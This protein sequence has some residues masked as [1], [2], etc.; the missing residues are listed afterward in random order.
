M[1]SSAAMGV[2]C[3]NGEGS[4][5]TLMSLNHSFPLESHRRAGGPF[6]KA[7]SG[8]QYSPWTELT[9]T[10]RTHTQALAHT[11]GRGPDSSVPTVKL[12]GP[13]LGTTPDR[14]LHASPFQA[15]DCRSVNLLV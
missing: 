2:L 3:G 9:M 14:T 6:P 12:R 5:Y 4:S 15:P 7:T 11:G 13:Q 8:S 1:S 10:V